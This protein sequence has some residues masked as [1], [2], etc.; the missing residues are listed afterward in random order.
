LCFNA[1][2]PLSL[3]CLH[4]TVPFNEWDILG[5][6]LIVGW[7][8]LRNRELITD[9]I[10]KRWW[11]NYAPVVVTGSGLSSGLHLSTLSKNSVA[12]VAQATVT[13]GKSGLIFSMDSFILCGVYFEKIVLLM[14]LQSILV[15]QFE[16]HNLPKKTASFLIITFG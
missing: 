10:H 13:L 6:A 11:R 9:R 3:A 8:I 4:H 2:F 16:K 7:K 1:L 12:E 15:Y 14:P 5:F